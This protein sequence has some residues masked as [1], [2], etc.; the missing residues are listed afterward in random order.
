LSICSVAG[1]TFGRPGVLW[2]R[3]SAF[4]GAALLMHEPVETPIGW[5][6]VQRCRRV[7]RRRVRFGKQQT[8]SN[9]LPV[10]L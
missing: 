2:M 8:L 5:V 10:C 3:C 6:E 9:E 7:Q 4:G 1:S